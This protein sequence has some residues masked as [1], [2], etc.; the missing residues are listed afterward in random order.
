MNIQTNSPA[1]FLYKDER[2]TKSS[3]TISSTF[4]RDTADQLSAAG[5]GW[6]FR[7]TSQLISLQRETL[8]SRRSQPDSSP[9]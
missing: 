5:W 6:V 9:L 8:A 1:G 2:L 7:K 4:T 3:R